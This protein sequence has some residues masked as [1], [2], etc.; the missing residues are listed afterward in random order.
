LFFNE[1]TE[2]PINNHRAMNNRRGGEQIG[3]VYFGEMKE[4]RKIL[5]IR[6]IR[7]QSLRIFVDIRY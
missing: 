3:Y 6:V 5:S 7:H 1:L 2:R 4:I